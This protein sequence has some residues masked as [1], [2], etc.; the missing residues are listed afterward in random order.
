VDLRTLL[1]IL[2]RRWIVVV[3]TILVAAIIG[4][5]LLA[6]VKPTYEAKGSL[7]L[8]TPVTK[9]PALADNAAS[10]DGNPFLPIAP[11]DKAAI[12]FAEVMN[13]PAKKASIA[14]APS[15]TKAYTVSV[16]QDAPILRVDT[17]DSRASV[18]VTTTRAVLTQTV[19]EIAAL[20]RQ[21]GVTASQSIGT[22]VL[23]SP[24][25][26]TALNAA[27]T[28]ALIA[29][30]ALAI[31][32]VLSVALLVESW[33][34]SALNRRDRRRMRVASP[35]PVPVA[36]PGVAPGTSGNSPAVWERGSGVPDSIDLEE[37]RETA[38][39]PAPVKQQPGRA[40][41]KPRRRSGFAS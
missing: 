21:K 13:N 24:T 7:L 8:L 22:E 12:A 33:A 5:Q 1:R 35:S 40:R 31:A 9:S 29:F 18:A 20:E 32:A 2:V 3:P 38:P 23:S 16:D 14:R 25:K 17:K 15:V 39:A 34:Q 41:A 37:P 28:R 36:A 4:H 10:A 26:A 19:S 30:I 11:L 6:S 27:R